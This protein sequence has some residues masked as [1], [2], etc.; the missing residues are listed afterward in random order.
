MLRA[1]RGEGKGDPTARIY[2]GS[3]GG[4]GYSGRMRVR[5]LYFGVLRE[6]LGGEDE[7]V[8]LQA[9]A[10]VGGLLGVLRE[11]T[12]NNATGD[13]MG[14]GMDERVWQ[15]LAVA[16]NR[17]YAAADVALREGDEVALLPPVSGG[18]CYAHGERLAPLADAFGWGLPDAG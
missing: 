4:S 3:S 10:T 15:S 9:G 13:A 14:K 18:C 8:E 5:L 11:R 2:C 1:R 7:V 6:L 17:E 16:V 12:S